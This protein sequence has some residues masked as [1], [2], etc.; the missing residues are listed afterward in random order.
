MLCHSCRSTF[1]SVSGS[2]PPGSTRITAC[3]V[4]TAPNPVNYARSKPEM[5][6]YASEGF[7]AVRNPY[8]TLS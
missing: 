5:M 3:T 8:S 4:L 1:I 6:K 7:L 2:R